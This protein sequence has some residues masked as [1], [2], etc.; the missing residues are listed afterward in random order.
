M[1]KKIEETKLEDLSKLLKKDLLSRA[2][3]MRNEIAQLNAFGEYMENVLTPPSQTS[4]RCA[5]KTCEVKGYYK[6]PAFRGMPK[7]FAGVWCW[8]H[9]LSFLRGRI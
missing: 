8:S 7:Q 1:M 4:R 9:A 6:F 3:E 5:V 2:E